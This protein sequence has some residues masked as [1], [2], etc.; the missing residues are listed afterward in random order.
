MALADQLE[1]IGK[2]LGARESGLLEQLGR[3][4]KRAGE[5]HERVREGIEGFHRGS[6]EAGAPHLA[7]ELSDPR[8]DDKHLHSVQFD[9]VRGRHR[10]IVTVKIAGEVTI[11][12]PFKTGKP[13]GPCKS[14]PLDD[15]EAIDEALSLVLSDFLE[16]AFAP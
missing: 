14:I 16:A 8:I 2:R 9:L 15:E 10:V 3:V 13:E 4:Q 12:G 1:E 7:V 5:L 6:R 11:V